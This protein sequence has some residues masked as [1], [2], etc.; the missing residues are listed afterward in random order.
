MFDFV[1][2]PGESV[3]SEIDYL[4]A[5]P[6]AKGIYARFAKRALDVTAIVLALPVILPII[7]ICAFLIRRDGGPAFYGQ[8]RVGKDGKEF[9]CWKLRSMVIDAE[10]RLEEHI[11]NDPAAKLEWDV[12]QKLRNDPRI[13]AV[14]KFIRK[15]SIDELPQLFCVLKGEMSL[16][17]PRP[18]MPDQKDLY[19][20]RAYYNL[21]PGLTGLWQVSD[22]NESSFA[23]RA[24]FDTKYARSLSMMTDISILFRTVGAVT[25]GTGM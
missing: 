3:A 14:G 8:Q 24:I 15:T 23:E 2:T 9:T 11:A 13:T 16:V 12:N 1:K 18:F 19:K 4:P 25:R 7:G 6:A 20:G 10:K 5:K 22:R 17:G 21:R